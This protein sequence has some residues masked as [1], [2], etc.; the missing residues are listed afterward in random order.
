MVFSVSLFEVNE[1]PFLHVTD[2]CEQT[3]LVWSERAEA[4]ED[5]INLW[6]R[7]SAL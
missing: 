3:R 2:L 7:L 4:R 1:G 5:F 6:L